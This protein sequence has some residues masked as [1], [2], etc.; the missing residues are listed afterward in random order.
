MGEV[1]SAIKTGVIY[2]RVSSKE[3]VEGTSLEMQER[4]CLEYAERNKI[5]IVGVFTDKGESAKTADR[6]QFMEAVQFCG[7]KN[8]IVHQFL[9]YKLDRFARNQL[10][11]V[12]IRA[13]L[14]KYGTELCSV[15]EPID[16]SPIGKALEGVLS[17]FAEFDNNVRAE[18]SKSGMYA[19]LQQG[20]WP[21]SAPLGYYRIKK[22]A[23]LTPDPKYAAYIRMIF[24][25]YAA[26]LHSFHS[27]AALLGER[28]FRTPSGKPPSMQL[29]EKILRNPIYYGSMEVK[30]KAFQGSFQPLIAEQL[31]WRCQPGYRKKMKR[32]KRVACNPRFP[33]RKIV[34]CAQCKRPLTGSASRGR[35]KYYSY[36]HHWNSECDKARSIPKD[37]FERHFADY[38]SSVSPSSRALSFTTQSLLDSWQQAMWLRQ[39]AAREIEKEIASL[40][41]ERE[42]VFELHRAG[43]YTDGEFAEQKRLLNE[44][45]Q[46]KLFNLEHAMAGNE[47]KIEEAVEAFRWGA[48]DT[49]RLWR[50]LC[51]PLKVRFQNL[52][53]PEKVLFDGKNFGTA[54][55]SALFQLNGGQVLNLTTR[56]PSRGRLWNQIVE[57]LGEWSE[58][59]KA[60]ERE[61]LPQPTPTSSET[62]LSAGRAAGRS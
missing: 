33:L 16:D 59:K 19:R 34:Q 6:A 62:S 31:F 1:N 22:G 27:L 24:E 46:G 40:R 38:M 21:W 8:P 35:S 42:Q 18:R 45:I 15:T 25:E 2:C 52:I 23:S 48:E 7:R 32:E 26:G 3:Q 28:G 51:Y 43:Q 58:F 11:H 37:D 20:V 9:V 57:E 5:Q 61:G 56:V 41:G 13:L 36:Y 30:G 39:E 44:R 10:D 50:T 14:T 12:S 54:S 4:V 17:I 55:L 29:M 47:F 53:F 60:V 49:A